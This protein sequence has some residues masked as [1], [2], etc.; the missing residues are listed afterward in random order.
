V[1]CITSV[2]SREGCS[3]KDL[4]IRFLIILFV[5][6]ITWW[7]A[8]P[9]KE[10]VKLGLDLRGGLDITYEIDVDQLKKL[11]SD[12]RA[13]S[14]MDKLD[15]LGSVDYKVTVDKDGSIHVKIND[16]PKNKLV[17]IEALM[18]GFVNYQF[19]KVADGEYTLRFKK[20]ALT[21]LIKDAQ[22]KAV[23]VIRNRVDELGV[24]EV[25][26]TTYGIDRIRVQIPGIKDAQEAIDIIGRTAILQFRLVEGPAASMDEKV[27]DDV[28]I[29][30]EITDKGVRYWKVQKRVLLTGD[31]LKNAY[32]GFD[33]MGRIAVDIE[34]NSVGAQKF[35]K[36]TNE[37]VGRLLAI[38][39]DQKV[40]SAPQ[41]REPIYGGRAQITGN[42]TDKEAK[43]LAIVLRA[44]ALPAPLKKLGATIVGPTLGTD[45]I[46]RGVKAITYGF[47]LVLLYMMVV[48]GFA[49]VIASSALVANFII[50]MGIMAYFNATLTLPG[51]AGLILTVG[52][53]VDA[54]VIIF[55]RIR[56][57]LAMGKTVGAAIDSGFSKAFWTIFDANMTTLITALVLY[58]YGTG[59]IRGFAV[60]LSA[61]IVA[62]MFTAI[63]MVKFI[64]DFFHKIRQYKTLSI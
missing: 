18:Q 43:K 40:Q 41:I 44:G 7:L 59:P 27:S 2:K 33:N 47:L 53:A 10:K 24:K 42:F 17:E 56:E 52:M 31:M 25:N 20:E 57:E 48:Y 14:I 32:V 46:R 60:T 15:E 6:G 9:L 21:K 5:L 11:T 29:L 8:F 30:P 51:I 39:L 63:F 55:E 4:R 34:F 1:Y 62:S 61:G 58:F 50:M 3:L 49:G 22:M 28:E 54:N 19:I 13:Q 35:A 12:Q 37:N 36:I 64:F 45:S 26:I 38:V 23:T 16:L